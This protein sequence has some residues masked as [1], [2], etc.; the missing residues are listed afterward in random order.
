MKKVLSGLLAVAVIAGSLATGMVHRARQRGLVE[1]SL[2][3]LRD[4]A[5]G[6]HLSVDDTPYGGGPDFC[7]PPCAGW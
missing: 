4:W 7:P 6:P 3:Q 5:S 1:V 2:H